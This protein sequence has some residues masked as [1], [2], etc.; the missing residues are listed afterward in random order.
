MERPY[1]RQLWKVWSWPP[2]AG[3]INFQLSIK[4]G[5]EGL[6]DNPDMITTFAECHFKRGKIIKVIVIKGLNTIL[7]KHREKIPPLRENYNFST[8]LPP[9]IPKIPIKRLRIHS[10]H[11]QN[12]FFY[13]V[14][15]LAVHFGELLPQILGYSTSRE[16]RCWRPR[17]EERSLALIGG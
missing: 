9:F 8:I 7:K 10:F 5:C 11:S 15:K 16:M 3:Q 4:L 14:H 13:L 12:Q 2:A 1:I 17:K 6:R